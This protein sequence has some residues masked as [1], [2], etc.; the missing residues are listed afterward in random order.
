MP[1]KTNKG[2]IKGLNYSV[3]IAWTR[4]V[5]VSPAVYAPLVVN[6]DFC[7]YSDKRRPDQLR[8]SKPSSPEI[9][10]QNLRQI[11]PGVP[12]KQTNKQKNR[13]R[14]QLVRVRNSYNKIKLNFN[15]L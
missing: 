13:Q 14:L 1:G 10:N 7:Y 5:I 6:N 4:G 9:P 15:D 12:D 11:G 2:Y 3:L 8:I